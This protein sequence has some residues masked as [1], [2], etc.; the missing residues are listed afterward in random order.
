M[1]DYLA[2]VDQLSVHYALSGIAW[3]DM[4]PTTQKIVDH[5]AMYRTLSRGWTLP[6]LPVH[7]QAFTLLV[8]DYKFIERCYQI[9]AK[10]CALS[11]G[12]EFN[13]C[14]MLLELS[15]DI[16][17]NPGPVNVLAGVVRV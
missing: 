16:E 12:D 13:R 9:E 5:A 11:V 8:P 1:S 6:Q 14:Q 17:L 7:T 4:I 10:K 3:D 15:G 2:H